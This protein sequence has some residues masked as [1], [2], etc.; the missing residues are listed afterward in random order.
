[1]PGAAGLER[2]DA[3]LD[4]GVLAVQGLERRDVRVGLVGDEAL[5]AVGQDLSGA[6][7]EQRVEA[8]PGRAVATD[9][10]FPNSAGCPASTARSETQRP[11][12]AAITARS[13]ST[14]PGS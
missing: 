12:S 13:Q 14:L 7:R 2:L 6:G 4:F 9:A 3:I 1:M 8:K 5:E 11:P 10:R